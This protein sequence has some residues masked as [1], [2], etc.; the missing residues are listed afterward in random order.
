MFDE[1]SGQFIGLS[2]RPEE[3]S[4]RGGLSGSCVLGSGSS[5]LYTGG[6]SGEIIVWSTPL[7]ADRN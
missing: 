5:E 3:S 2:P 1:H 7:G 6:E 4:S